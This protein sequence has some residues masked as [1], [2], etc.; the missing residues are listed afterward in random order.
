[1]F[2]KRLLLATCTIFLSVGLS[3]QTWINWDFTVPAGKDMA[4]MQGFDKFMKS[5]TGQ[6]LGMAALT[7]NML[8]P[9]DWTHSFTVWHDDIDKIAPFMDMNMVMTNKDFQEV[10][11]M[12]NELGIQPAN[13]ATGSHM[14]S[15]T[16][17]GGN[18]FQSIWFM[19]V[20]D[21]MASATAFG[22]MSGAMQDFFDKHNVQ[23]S[24]GQMSSGNENS[25]THYVLAS[26]KDY[27]TFMQVS[28]EASQSEAFQTWFM[29]TAQDENTRTL[30]RQAL[31][32][33]NIPQG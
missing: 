5:E 29:E 4:V 10:F 12:F 21:P 19:K 24:L 30:S 20:K 25:E 15:T 1:M 32:M 7:S 31:S 22:K 3:A 28:A 33:W 8:G 2:T 23:V 26:F 6:N 18:A 16:P 27:K 13:S 17:K 9:G 11:M 14:A